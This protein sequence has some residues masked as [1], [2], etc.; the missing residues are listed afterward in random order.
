MIAPLL[1]V[2][3]LAC[4]R[5]H[6]TLFQ[7]VSFSLDAGQWL[8]LEGGNGVGKTSLLRIL[9]GL[10]PAASGRV[11]WRGRAATDPDSTYRAERLYMGHQLALKEELS[12][13]ENLRFAAAVAGMPWSE[14]QALDALAEQGL[15][16]REHLPLRVLSQGQQRRCALARLRPGQPL[17]WLLDEPFVALDVRAVERLRVQLSQHVALGG[18]VLYTSHQTVTLDGEGRSF[19]LGA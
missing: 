4:E 3:A 1:E 6:L 11:L 15:S 10:S 12:A 17:L 19:R 18:A 14:S 7:G 9:C 16:G 5:G 13:L 2:Q 8:H